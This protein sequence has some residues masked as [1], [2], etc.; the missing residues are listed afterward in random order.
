MNTKNL[1]FLL[2]CYLISGCDSKNTIIE[3]EITPEIILESIA[4][5][6]PGSLYYS[7]EKLLM[8]DPFGNPN[9]IQVFDYNG[10]LIKSLHS[11]IP[12]L[13]LSDN[14]QSNTL[15]AIGVT[16]EFCLMKFHLDDN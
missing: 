3:V 4:T 16:P 5:R 11:N 13:R 7:D 2:I 6:M 12:I 10:N 8:I 9:F 1:A 14:I 15:F